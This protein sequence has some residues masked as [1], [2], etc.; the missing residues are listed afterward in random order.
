MDKPSILN[1]SKDFL[2]NQF[3]Q[4]RLSS[5][6]L[7]REN[8]MRK[9]QE[10]L[11]LLT[12]FQNELIQSQNLKSSKKLAVI[13]KILNITNQNSQSWNFMFCVFQT[14]IPFILAEELRKSV[15]NEIK[16]RILFWFEKI[17]LYE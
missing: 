4:K 9:Q 12:E 8:E 13:N 11:E 5:Q 14:S 6:I 17:S 15:S 16:Q 1:L 7:I 3:S 10:N 2:K